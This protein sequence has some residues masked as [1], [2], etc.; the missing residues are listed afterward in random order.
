MLLLHYYSGLIATLSATALATAV[1][2]RV[3]AA[4]LASLVETDL[5]SA[6][7]VMPSTTAVLKV[8]RGLGRD[9]AN[10]VAA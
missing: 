2:R 6:A 4:L 7:T 8:A 3:V 5:A 10:S 9:Q 1:V